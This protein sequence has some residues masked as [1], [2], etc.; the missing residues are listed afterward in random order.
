MPFCFEPRLACFRTVSTCVGLCESTNPSRFRSTPHVR[1]RTHPVLPEDCVGEPLWPRRRQAKPTHFRHPASPHDAP[2][3]RWIY[4]TTRRIFR[5]AYRNT[6]MVFIRRKCP[7][8]PKRSDG[9]LQSG[10]VAW[11]MTLNKL[12]G[13]DFPRGC[14]RHGERRVVADDRRRRCFEPASRHPTSSHRGRARSRSAMVF[15][16]SLLR[17]LPCMGV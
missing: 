9:V 16:S 3:P 14:V 6:T 17:I 5:P 12:I 1:L 8:P 11:A 7:S 10:L 2:P 15:V 4:Q 13:C